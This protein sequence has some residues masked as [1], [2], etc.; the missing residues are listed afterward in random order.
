MAAIQ[1][2]GMTHYPPFGWNDDSMSGLAH[3]ILADPAIP[4]EAKDPAR[5]PEP[6]R[7]EWGTDGGKSAAPA[8]RAQLIEGLDRVRAALDAFDPD[9]ILVWG[10]DQYE[11]FREDIVPPFSI[12]A[13]PDRVVEPYRTKVGS[14]FPSHWDDES[15]DLRITIKGRPDIARSLTAALIEDGFDV[16]YAYKPLHDDQLPHAFLNTVL[17]LDH[18]R[19]GFSWPMICMPIN[20]YGSKVIAARGGWRPFGETLELDP[21]SPSPRRLMDMGSSVARVLHDSPWRVS[22]I[23]SS[24]WSHAFLTDHTWRLRPDTPADKILY[25][26]LI[27]TDYATWTH[28]TTDQIVH[29]GQQEVLNWFPLMGAARAL[30]ATLAWSSFVET[31]VFNSNKVFA[32][33]DVV[34]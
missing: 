20:C 16:A 11:N 10:D 13:Y 5:W 4:S 33:W 27:A 28:T 14:A 2:L 1:L 21:P 24:S 32:A 34:S 3:M 7:A 8:H 17:F 26:A 19:T 9:V 22:I 25:D 23:A 18:R 12:L 30:G 29:A 15:K 31:W 6:M